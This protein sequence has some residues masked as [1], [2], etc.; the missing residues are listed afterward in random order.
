MGLTTRFRARND[1]C[2]ARIFLLGLA[3]ACVRR[4]HFAHARRGRTRGDDQDLLCV[5][6]RLRRSGNKG[7]RPGRT[8]N[9][10]RPVW[11]DYRVRHCRGIVAGAPSRRRDQADRGQDYALGPPK[12]HRSVG[13]R[14]VAVWF[15]HSA[16]VAHAKTMVINGTVTLNGS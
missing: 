16:R 5:G 11:P 1:G 2:V 14:R 3:G 10:C 15:D 13:R 4:G 8:R 7:G 12:R 6:E 9:P